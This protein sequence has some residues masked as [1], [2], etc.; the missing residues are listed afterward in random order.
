ML[1]APC[2]YVFRPVLFF[3]SS[4]RRHTRFDCDWSSDV[5]SSDLDYFSSDSLAVD[6]QLVDVNPGQRLFPGIADVSVPVRAVRTAHRGRATERKTIERLAR[7]PENRDGHE[8]GEHVVDLQGHHRPV[9][10][11][12]QL[13]ADLERDRRRRVKRAILLW[14]DR[15]RRGLPQCPP[16]SPLH[17]RYPKPEPQHC[18][19]VPLHPPLLLRT[20]RDFGTALLMPSDTR[21]SRALIQTTSRLSPLST[22][23]ARG[24]RPRGGSPRAD[25]PIR[26]V[27]SSTCV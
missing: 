26:A 17:P 20:R 19:G 7:A 25:R 12:E 11:E 6:D 24:H 21:A 16:R 2:E 4:R 23:P 1:S 3:F 22:S 10:L 14:P 5:C 18:P 13:P 15:G 8:L 9:T 27:G